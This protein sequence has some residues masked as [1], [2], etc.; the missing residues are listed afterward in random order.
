MKSTRYGRLLNWQ[1]V[2]DPFWHY[3]IGLS[4]LYIFDTG[5]ELQPFKRKQAAF[6]EGITSIE[7]SPQQTIQRL[8]EAIFVFKSWIYSGLGWN[9]EHLARLI[10]TDEPRSYQRKLIWW[11]SDLT[12]EGDH[13]T[14]HQAFR[15]HLVK[16]AP[17]LNRERVV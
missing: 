10:A 14:A 13:K 17:K 12:P 3:G 6:V 4:D 9:C 7:F 15:E 8:K 16:Y 2:L 1:N 5:K 11:V